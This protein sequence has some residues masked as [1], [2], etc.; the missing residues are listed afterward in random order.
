MLITILLF[1]AGLA[2][3][4]AGAEALVRGSSALALR[5]G[6]SPLVIGLTVVA[7]GTS[8]PELAVSVDSA[9]RGN[10][11]IALGNIIGSNIANIALI[12]GVTALIQPMLVQRSLVTAQIPIM[13]GVS[14][15]LWLLMLDQRL[16]FWNG[17]LL[18]GGLLV[19]I[20][21]SYH[22]SRSDEAAKSVE[23]LPGDV[24]TL[25]DK[26]WFCIVLIVLGLAALVGGGVLFVDAAVEIA[27]IFNVDETIIGLTIVAVG[28][29]MPEFA[30][31]L[32]AALRRQSD[33]ALG[34]IVG[35]NIFN[36]LGILGIASMI[37]PLSSVS[38]SQMDFAAM[39]ALAIILLPMCMTGRKLGR[40][41]GL[42]LLACYLAYLAYIWPEA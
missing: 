39:I 42:I 32:V 37:T 33:I 9:L 16:D 15:L 7:F 25:Q 21:F 13:I 14:V 8:S 18:A 6:V 31:S 30:T 12:L 36:I 27:R 29:S 34:N 5:L 22:N 35:S 17:V 11:S 3:L 24:A 20:Y 40:W 1:L 28:T 19:Y 41:E 2:I 38:F 10:S 26:A 23:I 4:V